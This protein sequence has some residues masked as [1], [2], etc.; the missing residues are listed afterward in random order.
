MTDVY[1]SKGDV[2]SR[3]LSAMPQCI[4]E[5]TRADGSPYIR[6]IRVDETTVIDASRVIAYARYHW[7]ELP[8]NLYLD[9]DAHE[10]M[11]TNERPHGRFEVLKLRGKK[12]Y[13]GKRWW[14]ECPM[15]GNAKGKLYLIQERVACRECLGLTIPAR[16]RHKCPDHDRLVTT[17]AS[18]AIPARERA[19]TRE[20]WRSVKEQQRAEKW[21]QNIS[22]SD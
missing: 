16:A 4:G 20:L 22:A 14:L 18:H 13:R 3:G 8:F 17:S 9:L 11:L 21:L 7:L 6:R 12:Q 1:Q 19:E 2:F 10:A 5:G 15:C